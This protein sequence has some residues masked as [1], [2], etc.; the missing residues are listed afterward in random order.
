MTV[1][2]TVKTG[3]VAIFECFLQKLS[4]NEN[5]NKH[6]FHSSPVAVLEVGHLCFV[7]P[8]T[9]PSSSLWSG[10]KGKQWRSVF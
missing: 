5:T 4:T 10:E 3:N 2:K 6:L 9:T 1:Y 7:T 8:E